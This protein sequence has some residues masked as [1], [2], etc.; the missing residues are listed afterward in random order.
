M[1]LKFNAVEYSAMIKSLYDFIPSPYFT[2]SQITDAISSLFV[3]ID[4][5]NEAAGIVYFK[6]YNITNYQIEVYKYTRKEIGAHIHKHGTVY[7]DHIGKRYKVIYQ[8]ARGATHWEM[9][10]KFVGERKNYFKFG[11]FDIETKARSPLCA[12]TISTT[13]DHGNSKIL[14]QG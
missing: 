9:P 7:S 1:I 10:V 13:V 8:L 14:L 12:L 2:R 3:R 6:N 4:Y 5:I 11:F